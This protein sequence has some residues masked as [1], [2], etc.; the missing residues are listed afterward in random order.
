[1][2]YYEKVTKIQAGSCIGHE[3]VFSLITIFNTQAGI[4][5]LTGYSLRKSNWREFVKEM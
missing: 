2:E 1:M 5:G 4:E 3:M